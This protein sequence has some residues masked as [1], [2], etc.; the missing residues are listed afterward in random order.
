MISKKINEI[1]LELYSGDFYDFT[2]IDLEAKECQFCGVKFFGEPDEYTCEPCCQ[3]MER[4][5]CKVKRKKT[6]SELSKEKKQWVKQ[7]KKSQDKIMKQCAG[8]IYAGPNKDKIAEEIKT[9][10]KHILTGGTGAW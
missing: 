1:V 8:A 10:G 5:Y 4:S 3:K 9:K 6:R 7:S 2:G